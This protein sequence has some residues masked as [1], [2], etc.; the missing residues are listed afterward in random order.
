MFE[1]FESLKVVIGNRTMSK[2][3]DKM[4]ESLKSLE[5]MNIL[6]ILQLEIPVSDV[7]KD[8]DLIQDYFEEN[9]QLK[10]TDIEEIRNAK[11]N[12]QK[13]S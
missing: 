5:I 13:V 11:L 2:E 4:L 6:D 10:P 8:W 12:V 1:I 3:L 7:F 9:F